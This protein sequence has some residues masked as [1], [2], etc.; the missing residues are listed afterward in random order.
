VSID[1][2][3]PNLSKIVRAIVE[4]TRLAKVGA[5]SRHN[6]DPRPDRNQHQNLTTS[7]KRALRAKRLSPA[8]VFFLRLRLPS[9]SRGSALAR[10]YRVWSTS[11]NAF[12]SYPAHRMTTQLN[13]CLFERQTDRLTD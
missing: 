13:S 4:T 6:V 9:T 5:F 3:Y 2:V 1:A 10:P 11:V 12:V 7:C 8:P